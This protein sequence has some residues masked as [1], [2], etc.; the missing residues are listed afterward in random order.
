[1]SALPVSA[2][3]DARRAQAFPVLAPDE[4]ARMHRFGKPR[5]FAD[6]EH[7]FATGRVSRGIYVVLAGAIRVTGRDGHGHDAAVTEHGPGNFSGEV[8]QLAG[9]PS[10]VDGVAVGET[11]TLEISTEQVHALLVAE[12]ALGEKLMRAM[13]LR[14]VAL[15]ESGAGGP[16]LIGPAASPDVARLRSF[17]S[18]NGIPHQLLDPATDSDAQAFITR[19]AP[20]PGQLPLAVCPDGEVLRNPTENEIARCIGMLDAGAE[21]AVYD[22]AIAG[23]GP[24]G[25]AAAVY[26]CSEGLSV[27]VI[28]ARAFGGQAGASARI[29]NYFG[30]PTGISGQALAGR[31]FTQAQKFG[32]RMLIPMEAVHLDCER[33]ERRQ[34][35]SLHLADGRAVRS[36]T[37]V[38]ASGARYRRPECANLKLMEGR[39]VWY[40]ASPIEAR[41][42]AGQ[43]VVLVGGGN[44]AGQAAVFLAATVKKLWMLV[45]GPGLA[46][47]MSQYLIDRIAATPNIELRTRTELIGLTGSHDA[48]IETVTWRRNETGERETHPLRHVFLFLGADPSTGW[49]QECD[50][51]VDDRGFV[52]TGENPALSLQTT[53]PGVFAIGDVR[54]GSVKRVGAAI[55]EGAAVVSQIH[56]FLA[57]PAATFQQRHAA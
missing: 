3:L 27:M 15:I 49:L 6:G 44:S 17:L 39:G 41:M 5:R 20:E 32:A 1:M 46:A 57:Q 31:G 55:G 8:S 7:V 4:I 16:V 29:E 52:T 30:F 23:A 11:D 12:A 25:L 19:Y 54:A 48:G 28:D 36:R 33:A 14:R 42:C 34:P 24:A 26:A 22:V 35:M 37:V 38:I 13:I 21:D 50:V 45:R 9:K 53:I 10:F 43:E 40:W 51:A 18:R 2:T 47:S 56:A